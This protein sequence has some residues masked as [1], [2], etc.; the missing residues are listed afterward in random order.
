M[1]HTL[2]MT[3]LVSGLTKHKNVQVIMYSNIEHKGLIESTGA[4][5][6]HLQL[7][8]DLDDDMLENIKKRILP[9][10]R[11][12]T[13]IIN[14]GEKFLPELIR[15][16]EE[17]QID[18]VLYDL[19]AVYAKWLMMYLRSQYKKGKLSRP[20]PK[21]V[22]TSPSVIFDDAIYPNSHEQSFL[23][24]KTGKI[25]LLAVIKFF[26]VFLRYWLFCIKF[27][28]E[29]NKLK[30]LI[31]GHREEVNLC[32]IV[33]EIQPRAHLYPKNVKFIGSCACK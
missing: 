13:D 6:R 7:D 18:L 17:E 31:V 29:R 26:F 2:P 27:G 25:Q 28:I 10:D 11:L 16:V 30:Y 4:E 33:P 15:C 8:R 12:F 1:G 20:P 22:M 5:F 19:G 24:E 9:I 14:A 32:L 3:S 23:P 21:A